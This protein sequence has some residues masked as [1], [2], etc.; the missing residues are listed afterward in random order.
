LIDI[1]NQLFFMADIA[2]YDTEKIQ[3]KVAVK[4]FFV[5]KG[6]ADIV[7]AIQY[8]YIEEFSGRQL[9]NLGFGDYDISSDNVSDDSNSNNGDVYPVFYT[10]LGTIPDFFES[11]PNA[12]LMVQ[13]SDSSPEFEANCRNNCS[14]KC[15]E[16]CKK[17]NRRINT[18]CEY[19]NKNFQILSKEYI[20]YGGMDVDNQRIIEEYKVGGRYNAVFLR[21]K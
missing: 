10:V 8:H 21:K 5:S 2:G 17:L 13:G 6:K 12:M 4:Y 7:K 20:F 19:V 15:A 14:R 16:K 3:E 18:Y 9:F 1:C 11:Y